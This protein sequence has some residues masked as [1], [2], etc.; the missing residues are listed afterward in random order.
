M[1]QMGIRNFLDSLNMYSANEFKRKN[2]IAN[3]KL[4]ADHN[5]IERA[6]LMNFWNNKEESSLSPFMMGNPYVQVPIIP[7]YTFNVPDK[8]TIR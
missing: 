1:K 8:I 2:A 4:Y 7:N 5:D 3:I 6:E